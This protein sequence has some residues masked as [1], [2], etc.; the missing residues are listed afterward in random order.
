VLRLEAPA[1][2]YVAGVSIFSRLASFIDHHYLQLCI[3]SELRDTCATVS[4]VFE[5]RFSLDRIQLSY[6]LRLD[7]SAFG[8]PVMAIARLE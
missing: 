1:T 3:T 5:R 8:A 7:F 2:V 6:F 4:C